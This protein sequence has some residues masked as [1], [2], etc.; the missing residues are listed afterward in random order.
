M[1]WAFAKPF[2]EHLFP[3]STDGSGVGWVVATL[4]VDYIKPAW[5]P[6]KLEIGHLVSRVGNSSVG[7]VQGL[8]ANGECF[9]T[10][11]SVLVWSDTHKGTSLPMSAEMKDLLR[12][13]LA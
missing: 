13:Y 9:A 4:T 6:A 8:F 5:Y 11:T 12:K 2:L 1:Q 3:G 10:A 7:L